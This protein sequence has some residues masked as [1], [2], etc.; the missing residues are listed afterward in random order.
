[1][2]FLTCGCNILHCVSRLAKTISGDSWDIVFSKSA[3][4]L[5]TPSAATA[6]NQELLTTLAQSNTPNK[7]ESNIIMQ[8]K[9]QLYGVSEDSS[10]RTMPTFV[11]NYSRIDRVGLALIALHFRIASPGGTCSFSYTQV[12]LIARLV[13]S[14]VNL[15]K[16][17]ILS[18]ANNTSFCNN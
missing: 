15:L 1:M 10:R 4:T 18:L 14:L 16:W 13:L 6:N 7:V 17:R 9:S 8:A 11:L 5:D 3:F 12:Y 2:G